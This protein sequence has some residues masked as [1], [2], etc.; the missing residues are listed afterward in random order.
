MPM[1]VLLLAC[2][3]A[4]SRQPPPDLPV[5][6]DEDGSRSMRA[7]GAYLAAE[8]DGTLVET[9]S[10]AAARETEPDHRDLL[11]AWVLD[12]EVRRATG[13]R[14]GLREVLVALGPTL[15]PTEPATAIAEVVGHPL[16]AWE[17]QAASTSRLDLGPALQWWGMAFQEGDRAGLGPDPGASPIAAARRARWLR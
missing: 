11:L 8:H 2:A 9:L 4:P 3:A 13:D 16:P 1:V 6:A 14:R 7:W 17:A 15:D 10:A 5:A 12:A